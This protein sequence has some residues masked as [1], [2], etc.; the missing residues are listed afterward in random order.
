M[1][2]QCKTITEVEGVEGIH[3]LHYFAGMDFTPYKPRI[4]LMDNLFATYL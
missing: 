4:T 3:I 1:N 2:N